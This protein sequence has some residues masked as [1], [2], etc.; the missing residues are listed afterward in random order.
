MKKLIFIFLILFTSNFNVFSQSH[1]S[2]SKAADHHSLGYELM[3]AD[4]MQDAIQQFNLAILYNPTDANYFHNRAY[5]YNLI[6]STNLAILDY[7]QAIRLNESRY[8]YYY[9]LANI[10][11]EHNETE[12]AI[13]YYSGALSRLNAEANQDAYIILFNR[14]NCYLKIKNYE[15]ALSDYNLSIKLNPYHT[16]S[17]ANSGIAKF[18]RHDTSGA[19]YDWY[20]AMTNNIKEVEPYYQ[21]YCSECDF[22]DSALIAKPQNE[23]NALNFDQIIIP[24][25][26]IGK[27]EIP[28]EFPGGNQERIKFLNE[29]IKYP[30]EAMI[31]GITGK[32][33]VSFL[34]KE[35]GS[36]TDVKI[37]KGIGGKCD[38]E[39]I[40]IVQLMPNWN[41]AMQNGQPI[42]TRL[43]MPIQFNHIDMSSPV[44]KTNI[45]KMEIYDE[46]S[47]IVEQLLKGTNTDLNFDRG[48][49]NYKQE[50]YHTAAKHFSKSIKR[51]G[52]L[53]NES[54]AFRAVCYYNLGMMEEAKKDEEK[55]KS[56]NNPIVDEILSSVVWNIDNTTIETNDD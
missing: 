50:Y 43:E 32:V 1:D 20:I 5:C 23:I 2:I 46:P 48:A 27:M 19:C 30:K 22:K 16:A 33:I 13:V 11:Q 55:A 47:D 44:P 4:K 26:M 54:L 34:V 14:A 51:E 9:L 21:K 8:D 41:P 36:L 52:Y 49:K 15:S 38:Q 6:D 40:R 39:A 7:L 56:F 25:S 24:D 53:K 17:Y 12:V 45:S 35:D 3:M 28:P 37:E 10:Y 42:E 18:H 29:N 31:A